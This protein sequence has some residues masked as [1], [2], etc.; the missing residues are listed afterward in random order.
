MNEQEI[1]ER[2]SAL[3]AAMM[4]KGLTTPDAQVTF[5]ANADPY[6]YLMWRNP[7]IPAHGCYS[8]RNPSEFCRGKNVRMSFDK[9]DDY[10]RDMAGAE[11]RQFDEF[12]KVVAQAVD[13]G[14]KN[15]IDVAFVSPL[16]KLMI[17]LSEN[18][19]TDQRDG[20]SRDDIKRY[21]D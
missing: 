5:N 8:E 18:A 21:I 7:S 12:M 13:L 16:E 14:R 15:G 2:L 4:A 11:K 10:V 17:S 9:A 6:V 20:L 3:V 19:I 1:N